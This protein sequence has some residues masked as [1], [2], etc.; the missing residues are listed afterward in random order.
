[1]EVLFPQV[2]E[3]NPLIYIMRLFIPSA[4]S[5]STV[6][7]LML[8]ENPYSSRYF[9]EPIRQQW[10]LD[11]PVWLFIIIFFLIELFIFMHMWMGSLFY[12]FI[13]LLNLFSTTY[14]ITKMQ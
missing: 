6:L 8:F 3:K 4:I 5:L 11:S 13:A 12:I 2:K 7:A 9:M 14:W 1:M 10:F